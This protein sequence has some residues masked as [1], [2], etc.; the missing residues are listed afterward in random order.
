MNL[1]TGGTG[2]LGR[3]LLLDLTLQNQP[4]K[5][6]CRKNSDLSR[7]EAFFNH[8]QPQKGA[9]LFQK[10]HWIEADVLSYYDIYQA[11]EGVDDVY[12][13]AGMVSYLPKDKEKLFEVNHQGTKHV[14]NAAL[15][16]SIRKFCHVSSIA[17]LGATN[18]ERCLNE[19][20][21]LQSKSTA[22]NYGKSKY[23][24]EQEVWRGIEEGLNA[25][26]V[27]PSV[28]LG[29]GDDGRSSTQ[30]FSTIKNGLKF[31]TSGG[32]G[33]VDV[34]DVSR[35]MMQLMNSD[36]HSER[37]IINGENIAYKQLFDY[38]ATAYEVAPPHIK[39]YPWMA[40]VYWRLQ[41]LKGIL[42][43]KD[44]LVTKETAKSAQSTTCYDNQK[45]ID[46]LSYTFIPI[47]QTVNDM[48]K[49]MK[50]ESNYHL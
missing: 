28:I 40:E 10:I 1:V 39:T 47:Q 32:S 29:F 5:A 9:E 27:N 8:L 18:E 7:V 34:R 19:M 26:I 15:E 46:A 21:F 2:L 48:V 20:D 33:F 24:G 23:E 44:P 38:I 22:S 13:C 49:E 50:K 43:G 3:Y 31:Y 25:V 37:F 41:R 12:H 6:T 14:V 4:V 17:S 30:I 35:I 45:I 11:M 42:T 16:Q 36:I